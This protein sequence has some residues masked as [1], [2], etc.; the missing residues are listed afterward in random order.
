M[1][2][3]LSWKDNFLFTFSYGFIT[4]RSQSPRSIVA[5][6]IIK[7]SG[8]LPVIGTIIHLA[9]LLALAASQNKDNFCKK[10]L[11]FFSLRTVLT[12]AP[13]I[14]LITDFVVAHL[15]LKEMH[16]ITLKEVPQQVPNSL[17]VSSPKLPTMAF[18]R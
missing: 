11:I 2:T 17:G 14:L 9:A 4:E 10:G 3:S 15:I 7:G 13:P 1:A 6:N 12:L 18:E 16:A 5:V 8:Y